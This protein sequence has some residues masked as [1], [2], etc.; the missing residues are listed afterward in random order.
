[1]VKKTVVLLLVVLFTLSFSGCSVFR[2]KEK[3]PYKIDLEIWGAFGDEKDFSDIV[4]EYKKINPYIGTIEYKK[5]SVDNYKED[6]L[7]AMAAGEGPDI[8]LTHNTWLPTF[9]NKSISAPAEILGE[10]EFRENFADVAAD[11]FLAEGQVY[12]VPLS[13]DSLALYYN[14]DMFNAAGITVPPATWKQ[15]EEAVKKITKIDKYGNF[16]QSGVAMGTADNINRSTDILGLLM[17]QNGTEMTNANH[18]RAT[19]NQVTVT[20]TGQKQGGIN[21]LEYYVQFSRLGSPVYTW[22][23]LKHYSID[24][25]FEG[26]VAM[27]LNYSWHIE[28][29]KNKN[30]KL[31]FAI[32]PVPQLNPDKPVNYANYWGLAVAKNKKR[33]DKHRKQYP[34][35][36]DSQYEQARVNEAWQFLKFMSVK[37]NNKVILTNVISGKSKEFAINF[38]PAEN[39][40]KKTGKPA[41]RRDLIEKQKNDPEIS[42]FAQGNLIA[43][44]WYQVQPEMEESILAE[45]IEDVVLG[46]TSASN[47][48]E[49]A[50]NRI[51]QL[52]R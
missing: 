51:T 32:A 6:L 5:F 18:T 2:Q 31:N 40:I 27:M 23:K 39:Y 11:D 45:A 9:Q 36:N 16:I 14:K 52:M 30:S 24:S 35:I 3:Y 44:S 21:A 37:N 20:E 10:K 25:F 50:V 7:D 33:E 4:N 42:A 38:D 12:A 22:N 26:T 15:L 19:F 48:L 41:A 46:K 1:M 28:T 43:R 13:I 34:K 8:F 29:I 49:V 47:A 17:F